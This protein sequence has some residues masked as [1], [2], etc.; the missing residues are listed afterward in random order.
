MIRVRGG[1]PGPIPVAGPACFRPGQR[2]RLICR[3]HQCRGRTGEPG[4]FTRTGYRDLL[5]AAHRRLPGGVIVV[6]RDNL[7]ARLRGA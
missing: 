6:V 5:I 7:P 1:G 3:R 4:A 2:A